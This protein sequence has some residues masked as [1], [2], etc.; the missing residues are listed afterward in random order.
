MESFDVYSLVEL[1]GRFPYQLIVHSP[2][3]VILKSSAVSV[4]TAIS[5]LFN[6]V[7]VF[8]SDHYWWRTFDQLARKSVVRSWGES[9]PEH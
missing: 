3:D 2:S 5:N 9:K 4:E 1:R 7:F 6:Q 8:S